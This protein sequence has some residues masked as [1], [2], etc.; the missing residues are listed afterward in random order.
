MTRPLPR[1][2]LIAVLTIV[3]GAALVTGCAG[4]TKPDP[5]GSSPPVIDEIQA[6]PTIQ[7]GGTWKIFA[8][9]HDPDGDM[10]S[11]RFTAK[12]PGVMYDPL[13]Q[14]LLPEKLWSELDGYFYLHVRHKPFE[15]GFVKLVMTVWIEDRGGRTSRKIDLP[16]SVGAAPP[17]P[18]PQGFPDRAL[19]PVPHQVLSPEHPEPG[20]PWFRSFPP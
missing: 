5:V 11:V 13:Q 19:A 7:W 2:A 10:W 6:S 4:L 20:A 16:L 1:P 3:L 15:T 9:A 18:D 17:S 14:V 12:Q 8:K